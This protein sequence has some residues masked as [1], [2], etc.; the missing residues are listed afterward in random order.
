MRT[1]IF[2]LVAL[3]TVSL[4]GEAKSKFKVNRGINIAHWLSQSGARGA[5]RDAYF[6]EK[7]IRYIASLG[8]DHVRI[9]IDEEQ[10]FTESGEKEPQAFF[11]LHRAIKECMKQKLRVI[12]DLHILRSHHFNNAERP[13]FTKRS[14]QET[15]FDCW[16]K[17]SGELSRYPVSKVAYE[18]MNEPVA[19]D[20]EDWNKVVNECYSVVR[21]LE[22]KRVIV[23]GS[24][25]WQ[26]YDQVKNLR[27]P[28]DD[29]NIIISFHY[30]NPF[31]VTHHQASWT[32]QKDYTGPIH[33]PGQLA[34]QEELDAYCKPE[35]RKKFQWFTTQRYDAERFRRDFQ[36]AV[37]V[38]RKHGL[39]VYCG[40]YGCL[41]TM[42]DEVRLNWIR[43]MEKVFDSMGIARALWCYREG[44]K[45]FGI[46]MNNTPDEPMIKA[47]NLKP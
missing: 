36:E 45:G 26:S 8:F 33:Y 38:A 16:R 32:D 44:E 22:P 31:P 43:D 10:M 4:Q 21:K 19:D 13:L 28:E 15:F 41:K 3:L 34:S 42:K 14:A 6:V 11:L 9:P 23:I 40:E 39:Q 27:V 25:R 29:P 12:V 46:L 7:D 20:P 24:N 1:V 5:S 35:H 37:N 18:L 47:M 2:A 17:L 30:Y